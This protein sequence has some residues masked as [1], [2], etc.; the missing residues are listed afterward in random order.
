MRS[1]GIF[2][3]PWIVILLSPV[4][5]SF[6]FEAGDEINQLIAR[7][8][9]TAA[10]PVLEAARDS[11]EHTGRSDESKAAVLND[12]GI[13][14]SQLG[15]PRDAQRAYEKAL[16]VWRNLGESDTENSA[17]TLGN[18]GIVYL[19]LNLLRKSEGTLHRAASLEEKFG[20]TLAAT[21]VWINLALVYTAE[22]RFKEAE[23]LLRRTIDV[24]EK[25]LGPAHG[26]VALALNNLA[27]LLEQQARLAEAEPLL[28]RALGIWEGQLPSNPPQLAAG[29]HNF[30]IVQV[31]LGR[32]DQAEANLKHAIE[33]AAAAL[34]AGHPDLASYRASYA[35]LLRQLG[36]E[37]E[38]RRLEAYARNARQQ[39]AHENLT[40]LTIDAEKLKR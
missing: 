31:R 38:A 21:K 11:A 13:V 28:A 24:R 18:L 26:D 35:H 29:F 33:I 37:E 6:S 30:A 36:R 20:D 16:V 8:D 12:L 4:C 39:Y 5:F 23:T 10:L 27:V 34:P 1:C 32:L 2:P 14:Y 7:G 9:F 22:G 25:E 40:G 3:A 19:K 17:H 15:H